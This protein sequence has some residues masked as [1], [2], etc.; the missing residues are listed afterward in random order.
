M[1]IVNTA[2]TVNEHPRGDS[3]APPAVGLSFG[4]DIKHYCLQIIMKISVT[5]S[6]I[7]FK[8]LI[9]VKLYQGENVKRSR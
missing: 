2:S 3:T 7:L 8:W 6:S 4:G 5:Y 1:P 9:S